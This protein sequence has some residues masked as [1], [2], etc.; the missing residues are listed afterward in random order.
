MVRYSYT[1]ALIVVWST[2]TNCAVCA[3]KHQQIAE[4]LRLQVTCGIILFSPIA[5][6]ESARASFPGAYPVKFLISPGLETPSSL[7]ATCSIV[8]APSKWKGKKEVFSWDRQNFVCFHLCPSLL[9]LSLGITER[10]LIPCFFILFHHIFVH[11]YKI[12][13]SHLFSRVKTSN[14]PSFSSSSID[15]PVL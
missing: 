4:S 6:A 3:L 1:P 15:A 13:P 8:S 7:W 9:I 14:F 11:V 12:P 2:Q 10:S 5:Q